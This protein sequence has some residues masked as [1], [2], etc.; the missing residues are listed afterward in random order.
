ME[1][2]LVLIGVSRTGGG[3]VQL[4][5]VEAGL[6]RMAEWGRRQRIRRI[7]RISDIA[8]APVTVKRIKD[9]IT[10]LCDLAVIEQLIVYFAGHGVTVGS[11]EFLLLTGA[12][13]DSNEAIYVQGSA[14]AAAMAPIGNIVLISDAC[15]SEAAGLFLRLRGNIIF[16]AYAGDDEPKVDRLYAAPLGSAAY[17]VVTE[18]GLSHPIYT[19]S[20]VAALEG[21][22]PQVVE[23]DADDPRF[24]VVRLRRALQDVLAEDVVNRLDALNVRLDVSQRP[25]VYAVSESTISRFPLEAG[26]VPG[27]SPP[28][29]G[30]TVSAEVDQV[31]HLRDLMRRLVGLDAPEDAAGVVGTN[32]LV[33]IADPR[34]AWPLADADAGVGAASVLNGAAGAALARTAPRPRVVV[35]GAEVVSAASGGAALAV[36]DGRMTIDSDT[37]RVEDVVLRL[38]DGSAVILPAAASTTTVAAF[39]AGELRDVAFVADDGRAV[40]LD[41]QRLR[42]AVAARLR[43]KDLWLTLAECDALVAAITRPGGCDPT[44]ALY[45]AYALHDLKRKDDISRVD[46][47]V[48]TQWGFR[49]FDLAMLTGELDGRALSADDDLHPSTPLLQRG[50]SIV[51][52]K[53]IELVDGIQ[54]HLL[55]SI[56]TQV[57]AAG[58]ELIRRVSHHEEERP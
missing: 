40:D 24:G 21:A 53:G 32:G 16:K 1:R 14:D 10:K 35:R 25:K 50:W 17:E 6:D 18:D 47:A 9:R 11:D 34:Q 12:P 2:A 48:A 31:A 3:L 19:E 57:D 55:S 37:G 7:H 44:L 13:D 49:L 39:A 20:L 30:G 43:I 51:R 41:A 22:H 45:A 29:A 46:D 27:G 8:D 42:G 38:N 23:R 56:W 52:I 54:P 26:A 33:V 58:L 36:A 5:A 28:Q 15:R 4:N